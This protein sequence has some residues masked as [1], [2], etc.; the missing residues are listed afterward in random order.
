MNTQPTA[1]RKSLQ[2][3]Q[4]K[5]ETIPLQITFEDHARE[6]MKDV[7]QQ[8]HDMGPTDQEHLGTGSLLGICNQLM[9]FKNLF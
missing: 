2:V 9:M 5:M 1:K 3:A 6:Q 7:S 8:Q 4:W